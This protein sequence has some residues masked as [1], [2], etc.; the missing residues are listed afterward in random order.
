MLNGF[1]PSHPKPE[2]HWAIIEAS[3]TLLNA[4]F[5]SWSFVVQVRLHTSF[6]NGLS[7]DVKEKAKKEII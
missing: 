6:S 3:G 7:Q 5:L 1:V 2:S 4:T